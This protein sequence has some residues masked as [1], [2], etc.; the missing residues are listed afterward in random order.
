M[1]V[2]AVFHPELHNEFHF[3]E[4]SSSMGCCCYWKSKPINTYKITREGIFVP[5][6]QI[7]FKERIESEKKLANIIRMRF[8]KD[9]IEN[10]NAFKKLKA[11]LGD[12]MD[13]GEIID[14]KR[15]MK[16]VN[17]IYELKKEIH[18]QEKK[19]EEIYLN[20]EPSPEILERSFF[21]KTLLEQE[22]KK[23]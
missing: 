21:M 12:R 7:S 19:R 15:L 11:R 5:Q 4:N 10:D 14:D 9:P 1:Q 20:Q 3:A 17:E 2:N 22:E 8:D 6:K 13:S 16:I 23:E 18:D